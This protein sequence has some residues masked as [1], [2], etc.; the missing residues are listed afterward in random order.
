[1]LK[2]NVNVVLMVLRKV[3]KIPLRVVSE[4]TGL[5]ISYLSE[6]ERGKVSPSLSSI[7][8]IADAYG[9]DVDIVFVY[10]GVTGNENV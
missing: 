6:I 9:M 5:S 8:K 7:S 2:K 3:H 1:M 4:R 10:R